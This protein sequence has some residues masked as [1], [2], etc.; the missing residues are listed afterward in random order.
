M[1]RLREQAG[2]S[3]EF[4]PKDENSSGLW[5]HTGMIEKKREMPRV[6]HLRFPPLRR[7]SAASVR[8]PARRGSGRPIGKRSP[9][10]RRRAKGETC[11]EGPRRASRGRGR[12]AEGPPRQTPRR[13]SSPRTAAAL[14]GEVPGRVECSAASCAHENGW[15]RVRW[16]YLVPTE[17]FTRSTKL[18]SGG[19]VGPDQRFTSVSR[20]FQ[21]FL[22]LRD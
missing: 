12:P 21:P 16:P 8:R 11:G 13:S 17:A 15:F 6:P 2:S 4:A 1:P 9:P 18:T 7:R 5:V 14:G 22:F 10:A 3:I 20:K 19:R